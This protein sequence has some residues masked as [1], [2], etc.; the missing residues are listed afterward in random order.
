MATGRHAP[1]VFVVD[2][3][4]AILMVLEAM[5]D[6]E[7]YSVSTLRDGNELF[8]RSFV[9]RPDLVLCDVRM[10]TLDGDV[11]TKLL[12]GVHGSSML[13]L[14]HSSIGERELAA[15]AAECGADGYV[16]KEGPPA[17]LLARIRAALGGTPRSISRARDSQSG[18]PAR[19]L[20][21]SVATSPSTTA[22]FRLDRRG[23]ARALPLLRTRPTVAPTASRG[24][25]E[26]ERRTRSWARHFV[27]A[28][29]ACF[30]R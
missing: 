19:C 12:K 15:R 13:V 5:L 23:M 26:S 10:P 11:L 29:G 2:D 3:S 27:R 30:P 21:S 22:L 24:S 4:E 16:K 20:S 18:Q 1:K 25:V 28:V 8:A 14:L 6:R 7:G 9:E 17:V